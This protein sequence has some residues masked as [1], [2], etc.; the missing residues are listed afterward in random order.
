MLF[1]V[2]WPRPKLNYWNFCINWKL[3]WLIISLCAL[4]SEFLIVSIFS[5]QK[6]CLPGLERQRWLMVLI[7]RRFISRQS[8]LKFRRSLTCIRSS[9]QGLFS[10]LSFRRC[11]NFVLAWLNALAQLFSEIMFYALCINLLTYLHRLPSVNL[12]L[13]FFT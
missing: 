5:N 8:L 6:F 2:S 12:Y 11:I 4:N 1:L 13:S 10:T 9:V 7:W 3:V